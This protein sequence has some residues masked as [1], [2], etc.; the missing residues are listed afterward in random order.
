MDEHAKACS[1]KVTKEKATP[2]IPEFPKINQ[3]LARFSGLVD[4]L[5]SA[6]P[7]GWAAKNSP[8]FCWVDFIFVGRAYDS[9]TRFSA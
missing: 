5:C 9:T 3:R 2:L 4:W 6:E 7:A 8:R 1:S